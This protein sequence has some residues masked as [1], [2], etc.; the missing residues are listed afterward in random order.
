MKEKII[1]AGLQC[2]VNPKAQVMQ[3]FI[4]N[5][6]Y[7]ETILRKI[8]D[9]GIGEMPISDEARMRIPEEFGICVK[10]VV[11]INDE[12]LSEAYRIFQEKQIIDKWIRRLEFSVQLH[13]K[14]M[15]KLDDT[16]EVDCTGFLVYAM[17][18]NE[19]CL[20]RMRSYMEDHGGGCYQKYR[21]SA[22]CDTP[23]LQWFSKEHA[24]DVQLCL[25]LLEQI[26]CA[27]END[28]PYRAFLSIAACGYKKL[29]KRV[30]QCKSIDGE[31]FQYLSDEDDIIHRVSASVLGLVMA[32][33]L[34]I[35]VHFDCRFCMFLPMMEGYSRK[36]LNLE[37]KTEISETGRLRYQDMAKHYYC[38]DYAKCYYDYP[39]KGEWEEKWEHLEKE[40]TKTGRKEIQSEKYARILPIFQLN[41][42][43]LDGIRLT[44]DEAARLFSID[45]EV[46]WE[47]YMT[48]LLV[49]AMC[50]Y[51]TLLNQLFRPEAALEQKNHREQ[52]SFE[53]M[54]IQKQV[55][56]LQQEI[57]G[58][59]K[60]RDELKEQ[61]RQT[62]W[63]LQ[64]RQEQMLAGNIRQAHEKQELAALRNYISQLTEEKME[65]EELPAVVGSGC[66]LDLAG[67]RVIVIGGHENW[68]RRFREQFPDWQFL[69]ANKNNFDAGCIR[70]K[71]IIIVNTAILKH[72]CYYRI[73]AERS[74]NQAILYVREN[75]LERCMEE[76]KRQLGQ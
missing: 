41:G 52:A 73:M 63:R 37:A 4:E 18:K 12:T 7:K 31:A 29:R 45:P 57:A 50:K 65:V 22:Y 23:L 17:I 55:L 43:M 1:K 51:I 5:T 8:R 56:A 21:E 36:M 48:M 14:E 49:A 30:K 3:Y 62:E 54:E 47:N 60:E 46:D 34:R 72:S 9:T 38:T 42:R 28:V 61:L 25:G 39:Y 66:R 15:L 24:L 32:E 71:E 26:R 2:E 68:Q 76:L 6:E 69:A 11:V 67:K 13:L 59:K 58:I 64:K 70:N 19:Q 10:S 40:L 75:N 35:P 74:E 16:M 20:K 44:E 27:D 33:E 53:R